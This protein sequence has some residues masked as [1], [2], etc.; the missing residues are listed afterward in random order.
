MRERVGYLVFGHSAYWSSAWRSPAPGVSRRAIVDWNGAQHRALRDELWGKPSHLS[1]RGTSTRSL[2]PGRIH[3][4][5]YVH[6]WLP[7]GRV[8]PS[9]RGH[10]K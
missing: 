9:A 8:E 10:G 1:P 6:P 5:P 7:S 3:T 4:E 2:P